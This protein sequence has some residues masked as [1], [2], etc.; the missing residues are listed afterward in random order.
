MK[1]NQ[2]AR[3]TSGYSFRGPIEHDSSGDLFVV[4]AKNIVPD[5]DIDT[6]LGFSRIS[7]DTIRNPSCLQNNDILLVSKSAGSGLIR[8][9]LF[10]SEARNVIPSSSIHVLRITDVT[11]LP[12]FLSL[13]LNAS[14]GQKALSFIVSGHSS[15]RSISL[16][17]LKDL[18]IPIPSMHKQKMIISL[19][20]N[21]LQQERI[22]VRQCEL[23]EEIYNAVITF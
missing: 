2:I 21:I 12:K 23:H 9:S 4:Q 8:S 13:Y 20:E 1:L 11:V 14:E 5:Q 19:R 10:L 16:K 6:L 15:I 7:S 18:E 3:I 22:R 17:Q